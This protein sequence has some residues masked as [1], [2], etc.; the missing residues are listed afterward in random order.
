MT[1]KTAPMVGMVDRAYI[2][3]MG[4][5]WGGVGW[6]GEEPPIALVQ[7]GVNQWSHSPNFLLLH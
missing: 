5:G 3:R 4:V 6:R 2:P 7:L 1:L